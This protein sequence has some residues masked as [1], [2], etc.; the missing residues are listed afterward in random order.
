[1]SWYLF[2]TPLGGQNI[3][4]I[5][6]TSGCLLSRKVWWTVQIGSSCPK[7]KYFTDQNR[8]KWRP[9]ENDFLTIF[10]YKNECCIEVEQKKEIKNGVICLVSMLPSWIVVLKLSKK[11]HFLQFCADLSQKPKSVKAIYIYESES[12]YYSLSE[13][14]MVYRGLSQCSWDISN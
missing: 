8:Q 4:W 5:L 1:M 9:H 14:D 2:L 6:V 12:S 11:V 7:S 10:K 3:I 13:N